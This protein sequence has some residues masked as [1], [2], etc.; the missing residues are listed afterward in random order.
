M[1]A[2]QPSAELLE[3]CLK[4]FVPL[5]EEPCAQAGGTPPGRVHSRNP[6]RGWWFWCLEPGAARP[7]QQ[8][9]L[10]AAAGLHTQPRTP[11]GPHSP[12]LANPWAPRL[13]P[14][15]P[16]LCTSAPCGR[17]EAAPAALVWGCHPQP[18]SRPVGRRHPGAVPGQRHGDRTVLALRRPLPAPARPCCPGLPQS[19]AR[20]ARTARAG[21][22]RHRL[23]PAIAEGRSPA[24]FFARLCTFKNRLGPAVHHCYSRG[25]MM[26]LW[27]KPI[28]SRFHAVLLK[29]SLFTA[30]P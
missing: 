2:A 8:V 16:G 13:N 10:R 24:P 22:G 17:R 12:D 11:P 14:A 9:P 26:T 23:G 5:L 6:I 29:L 20:T 3:R 7:L 25:F 18:R 19:G 1:S 30:T 21:P 27:K 15:Q 4:K 28:F